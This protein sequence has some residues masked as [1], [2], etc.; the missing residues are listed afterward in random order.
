MIY[1]CAFATNL[2]LCLALI[3]HFGLTGA[4][5]STASAIVVESVLLYV[6]TKRRLGLHI[7][8]FGR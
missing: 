3:P 1:A 6:V 7:F 8:V 5:A 4:A 2:V